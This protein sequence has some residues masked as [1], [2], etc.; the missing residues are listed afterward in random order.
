MKK[1]KIAIIRSIGH[2]IDFK[3]YNCQELGLAK[4]LSRFYCDVDVYLAGSSGKIEIHKAESD[5]VG[6]VNII[7]IPFFSVPDVG[8]AIYPSLSRLLVRGNYDLFHVNEDNEITTFMV[9]R[10]GKKIGVP[11]FMYQGMY[12]PIS[13][14]IMMLF[15]KLFDLIFLP[16]IKEN[17]SLALAKTSAAERYLKT[18]GFEKTLVLP[19]GLDCDAFKKSE[20]DKINY[21]DILGLNKNT[22]ILL[23]VGVFEKRRNVQFMLDL[24]IKCR[25]INITFVMVGTGP[26][27]SLAKNRLSSENIFNVIMLGKLPQKSLPD[28]YRESTLFVLPS[29]YEIYGMVALEAMY[30]AV[31]VISTKT[32]GP[33][34]LIETNING[35]L[36]D[37]LDVDEWYEVIV[38]YI[39]DD[40]NVERMKLAAQEK[41]TKYLVWDEIAKLYINILDEMNV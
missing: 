7:R 35:F 32:A 29:S 10:L 36:M 18:R 19:V 4:S 14:R 11:V 37:K 38:K 26:E 12:E 28:L 39:S 24:A 8:Q 15:R 33:L 5:N 22:H 27:F 31:P 41:V 40:K 23:Y 17:V 34:D 9:A 1:R 2:V 20:I 13:G 6:I 21:R 16:F 3:T 25:N 30:F